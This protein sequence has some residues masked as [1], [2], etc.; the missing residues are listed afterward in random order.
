[1]RNSGKFVLLLSLLLVLISVQLCSADAVYSTYYS[2]WNF[3]R[4]IRE[5][6]D[7]YVI[8]NTNGTFHTKSDQTL[9]LAK[10]NW[11][12]SESSFDSAQNFVLS[13][14]MEWSSASL[15]PNTFNSG[16]G[17]IF[18]Q[19]SNYANYLYVSLRMDGHMYMF[20]DRNKIETKYH[21]YY[22]GRASTTGT[23]NLT[24]VANGDN[25]RVIVDGEQLANYRDVIVNQYGAM[26]LVVHS[27]T[28]KDW[29]IKCNFRNINYYTW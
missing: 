28:N 21:D 3:D 25:I 22:Y 27:G 5:L 19:T 8:P 1:M 13:M 26:H 9:M 7:N 12:Q 14:D 29:G 16:C 20:A 4:L 18:R 15:T 2:Y 24:I 17:L 10:I 11:W 6:K 23:H